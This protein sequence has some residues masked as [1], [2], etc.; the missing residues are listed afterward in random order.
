MAIARP[1]QTDKRRHDPEAISNSAGTYIKFPR[2]KQRFFWGVHQ[3]FAEGELMVMTAA[4][5][6]PVPLPK[7]GLRGAVLALLP[8]SPL[9]PP[10]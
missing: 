5:Q 6:D 2:E 7:V 3:L 9:S 8:T 10:S 4:G 1:R